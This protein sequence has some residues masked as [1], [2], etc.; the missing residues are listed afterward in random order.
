[1]AGLAQALVNK[2]ERLG[3]GLAQAV[4]KTEGLGFG[5]ANRSEV[6]GDRTGPAG[7]STAQPLADMVQR[8]LARKIHRFCW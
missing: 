5:L 4:D 3:A 6:S 8:G 1:M 2:S 7:S